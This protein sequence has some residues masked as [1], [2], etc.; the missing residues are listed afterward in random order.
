MASGD[1]V[2][3]NN[4]LRSVCLFAGLTATNGQPTLATDGIPGFPVNSV[5]GSDS[6]HSAVNFGARDSSVMVKGTASGGVISFTGRLWGYHAQLAQWIP[7][8]TGADTTK[9]ILNGGVAI[10]ATKTNTVLHAE[11]VLYAGHFDRLY[12]EAT[13]V[14]G[15]AAT[16]EAWMVTLRNGA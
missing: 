14:A 5:Y 1:V 7:L 4:C 15:T 6:G 10:G 11:P 13:A 2:T 9:A 16:F 12:L 3:T 8:G